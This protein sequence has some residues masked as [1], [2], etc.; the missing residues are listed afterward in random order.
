MILYHGTN[1]GTPILNGEMLKGTWLAFHRF[2]AFRIAE[3]RV[4]QRGGSSIIIEINVPTENIDKIEGRD[5][6]TY[7]Y[8]G[9]GYTPV[10]THKINR[11]GI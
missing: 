8:S 11:V 3:R 10:A 1:D 4:L 7:R 9:G 6:P 2:H 5:N